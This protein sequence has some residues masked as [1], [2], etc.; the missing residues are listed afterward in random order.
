MSSNR[1]GSSF[2]DRW[3]KSLIHPKAKVHFSDRDRLDYTNRVIKRMNKGAGYETTKQPSEW[4][5]TLAINGP[6]VGPGVDQCIKTGSV[7]ALTRGEARAAIKRL[8][9]IKR[10]LPVGLILEK[11]NGTNKN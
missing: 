6:G 11:L 1:R 7:S 5:Y 10:R 9:K 4:K 3:N 8:Y 2:V